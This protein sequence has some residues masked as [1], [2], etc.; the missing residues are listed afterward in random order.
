MNES[1]RGTRTRSKRFQ[2]VR[3]NSTKKQGNIVQQQLKLTLP[4][5]REHLRRV[6][7]RIGAAILEFC[8]NHAGRRFYAE[9]LRRHI[10]AEVGVTAPGSADRVLRDLR[11]RGYVSYRV[12]NRRSSEYE[13]AEQ[14]GPA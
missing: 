2:A 9:Q 14:N 10:A 5:N 1:Q 8:K 6:S 11:R 4:S 3:L 12:I 7:G 13:L